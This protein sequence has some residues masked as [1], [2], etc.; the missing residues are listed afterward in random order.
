MPY[1][2]AAVDRNQHWHAVGH[3]SLL[4]QLDP[5]E[6]MLVKDGHVQVTQRL[7]EGRRHICY[8]L[9]EGK[10]QS[11][12]GRTLPAAKV[13]GWQQTV[14]AAGVPHNR[15]HHAGCFGDG[16]IETG[17]EDLIERLRSYHDVLHRIPRQ[18]LGVYGPNRHEVMAA[19]GV[20]IDEIMPE[21]TWVAVYKDGSFLTQR[22][23][24]N[25][26]ARS[27]AYIDVTNL[28]VFALLDR[29][30]KI[31]LVQHMYRGTRLIYRR[32]NLTR[33]NVR[34]GRDAHQVV[35]MVGWQETIGETNIQHIAYC[36]E[37]DRTV[38]MAGKFNNE[39]LTRPIQQY[40][41]ELRTVG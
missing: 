38:L 33:H 32:R 20:K 36:F 11:G 6:I 17:R 1:R 3:P 37:H 28:A 8:D 24:S 12:S 23:P 5:S 14:M 39:S 9:P 40:D 31:I 29:S 15:Q 27:S 26:R 2:L 10:L 19:S 16:L 4:S 41:F 25:G 22:D 18:H 21:Y 7:D 13:I 30:C 35:H 34:T